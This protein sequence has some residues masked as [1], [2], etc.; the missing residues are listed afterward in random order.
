MKRL[1]IIFLL[2]VIVISISVPIVKAEGIVKTI[3]TYV[4]SINIKINGKDTGLP[5]ITY[6]NSTYVP[7]RNIVEI[8]GKKVVWNDTSRTIN[9]IDNSSASNN[10]ISEGI[11]I[12]SIMYVFSIA[13][14]ISGAILLAQMVFLRG[15]NDIAFI[16][17]FLTHSNSTIYGARR[18]LY[19]TWLSKIGFFYILIGLIL[20]FIFPGY[21]NSIEIIMRI[22]IICI[23]VFGLLLFGWW[24]SKNKTSSQ[25][26]EI[27][28]AS[29]KI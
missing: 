25:F 8:F 26:P 27:L 14:L 2:L 23:I 3:T 20:Y 10:S 17:K 24:L 9:I 11:T 5:N 15:K 6:N 16:T 7:L 19:E 1:F 21:Y 28:R 12:K 29:R 22:V 13:F 4:N 18:I